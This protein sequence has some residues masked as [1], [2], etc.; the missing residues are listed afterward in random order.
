LHTLALGKRDRDAGRVLQRAGAM[1]VAAR[2]RAVVRAQKI[3]HHRL[4]ARARRTQNA[5]GDLRCRRLGDQHDDAR[6]G[7]G[8]EIGQPLQHRDS[9]YFHREIM[10]AGTDRL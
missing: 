1:D 7:I 5:L 3:H 10:P 6:S 9:A 4:A 8:S 2:E